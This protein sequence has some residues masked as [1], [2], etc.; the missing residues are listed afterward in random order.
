MEWPHAYMISIPKFLWFTRN[1]VSWWLLY[2]ADREVTAMVMEVNNSFGE[3]KAAFFRLIPGSAEST[4][5]NYPKKTNSIPAV[6]AAGVTQDVHFVSSTSKHK[7]YKGNW[8][9]DFFLSPFEKVEGYFTTTCSDPCNPGS[10]TK[11]PLHSNTTLYAP[12]G[13]PKI[14]SRLYSWGDPLDPL[15]APPLDLIRFILAWG[16][17]GALSK[18]RI[19]YEALRV[20]FRGNLTYHRKPE[21]RRGNIPRDETDFEK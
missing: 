2:S 17:V 9:K 1:A 10:G 18:P 7:I 8:D 3:R 20:R 13:K 14:I 11:G 19:I 12:N 16:Y 6:V 4:V 21:V 5:Q 15:S